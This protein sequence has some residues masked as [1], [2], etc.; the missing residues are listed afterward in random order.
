MGWC[1]NSWTEIVTRV[2]IVSETEGGEVRWHNLQ[3]EG[4][5][6][7]LPIYSQVLPPFKAREISLDV[8]LGWWSLFPLNLCTERHIKSNHF[9]KKERNETLLIHAWFSCVTTNGPWQYYT[10][11]VWEGKPLN[12]VKWMWLAT[13]PVVMEDSKLNEK[14]HSFQWLA[15]WGE[16]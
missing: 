12:G 5:T 15:K 9:G 1:V 6:C 7:V 10:S 4:L 3:R 2:R 11:F 16:L 14:W 13:E 8:I